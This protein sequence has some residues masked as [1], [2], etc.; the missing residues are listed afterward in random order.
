MRTVFKNVHFLWNANT[1]LHNTIHEAINNHV[2]LYMRTW[3]KVDM[4]FFYALHQLIR[5]IAFI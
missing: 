5:I 3:H 4:N 2:F 1:I